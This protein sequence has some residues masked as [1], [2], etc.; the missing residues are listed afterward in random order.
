MTRVR[1]AGQRGAALVVGLIM[2][3]LITIMLITALNLGA[4]NFRSV[5]NMQFREEAIA[6]ANRAIE[7]VISSN[8]AA[9]PTAQEINVDI[10]QDDVVDYVVQVDE[11]QCVQA[12]VAEDFAPSSEELGPGLSAASTWNTVWDIRAVV[13]PEQNAGGASVAVR[14]G[15]RALLTQ[16]Q[17]DTV[18]P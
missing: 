7:L 17:R 9:S 4:A 13:D 11:P 2:L 1:S 6:A 12:T 18:C 10:D 8:F 5:S 3:V 16:A 14:A 15:V